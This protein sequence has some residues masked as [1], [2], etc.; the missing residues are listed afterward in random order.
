MSN[1]EMPMYSTVYPKVGRGGGERDRNRFGM[2]IHAA[3]R[4]QPDDLNQSLKGRMNFGSPMKMTGHVCENERVT[5][6][7]GG[8][9]AGKRSVFGG[10]EMQTS[11]ID[12]VTARTMK[13]SSIADF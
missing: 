6:R 10:S 3:L 1:P 4:E 2:E 13:R 9:G 5:K 11:I 8:A 7:V 12:D